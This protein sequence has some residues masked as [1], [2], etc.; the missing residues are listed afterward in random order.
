MYFQGSIGGRRG[1]PRLK[2]LSP[3]CLPVTRPQRV[4][5]K[6]KPFYIR[7]QLSCESLH[8]AQHR[9]HFTADTAC[10]HH[11][12]ALT[13]T[14]SSSAETGAFTCVCVCDA[15]LK[16][17][18]SKGAYKGSLAVTHWSLWSNCGLNWTISID[19]QR[20][21]WAWPFGWPIERHETA[22][23]PTCRPFTCGCVQ[24]L[25]HYAWSSSWDGKEEL[26]L[27]TNVSS[28]VQRTTQTEWR[29]FCALNKSR[30]Q[31]MWCDDANVTILQSA[32]DMASVLLL[33]VSFSAAGHRGPCLTG[34]QHRQAIYLKASVSGEL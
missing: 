6:W 3:A 34:G 11:W 22:G 9:A 27:N 12:I 21:H 20:Y 31:Q 30:E 16:N 29:S 33:F 8:S 14:K 28:T 32:T 17:N 4:T 25:I 18:S 23:I 5:T 26:G 15:C 1:P 2:G 19:L 24:Q 13:F 10:C 7:L